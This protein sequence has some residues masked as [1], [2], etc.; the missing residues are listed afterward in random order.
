MKALHRLVKHLKITQ[1]KSGKV[2]AQ[3]SNID[4]HDVYDI[5]K[6]FESKKNISNNTNH[7]SLASKTCK[8]HCVKQDQIN[9]EVL[10]VIQ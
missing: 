7:A 5:D 9:V 4:S 3:S 8:C 1:S 2:C 6:S 10:E